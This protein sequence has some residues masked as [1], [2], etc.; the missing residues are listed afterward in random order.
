MIIICGK[1]QSRFDDEFRTTIC[2]HETFAANNGKNNFAHH[3]ESF[4]KKAIIAVLFFA[5][6]F[7]GVP[8]LH[9]QQVA[10]NLQGNQL[11]LNP[12]YVPPVTGVTFTLSQ[13][14]TTTY[15]YWVITHQGGNPSVLSGPWVI[16]Q[17]R[18]IASAVPITVQWQAP[19]GTGYT[20]DLLRT[21]TSGPPSG[22]GNFAVV[23]ATP[24][25]RKV[26]NVTSLASYTVAP[27]V[28]CVMTQSAATN[29]PGSGGTIGGTVTASNVPFADAPDHLSDT[30]WSY[31][32]VTG[33]DLSC[34]ANDDC[35]IN[36]SPEEDPT[37]SSSIGIDPTVVTGTGLLFK[38]TNAFGAFDMTLSGLP[39]DGMNTNMEWS[40]PGSA[41]GFG[42]IGM[43]FNPTSNTA[44]SIAEIV[45]VNT[46]TL[47][48][49][50]SGFPCGPMGVGDGQIA[51]FSDG[52]VTAPGALLSGGGAFFVNAYC[53]GFE[54]SVTGAY[55]PD[56]VPAMSGTRFVCIDASGAESSSATACAGT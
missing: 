19:Q 1:C 15:Y 9:A 39:G 46:T 47:N 21:T 27:A 25:A 16:T 3:P 6:G 36:F 28:P 13:T 26:D 8:T 12:V 49:D 4:L 31:G 10:G 40:L 42:T 18:A 56:L 2:P 32:T 50:T 22:T 43:Y 54:W 38:T 17:A 20:Y 34:L 29:C 33:A 41:L 5:F 48:P 55:N 7:V 14:G 45:D 24:V 52:D 51:H 44:K 35:E 37:L 30:A 53:D 23:A 11:T